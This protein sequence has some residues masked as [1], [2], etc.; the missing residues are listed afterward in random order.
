MKDVKIEIKNRKI[1]SNKAIIVE[2]GAGANLKSWYGKVLNTSTAAYSYVLLGAFILSFGVYVSSIVG[3][4]VFAITERNY[5]FKTQQVLATTNDLY[6]Q[7]YD[8]NRLAVSG[9]DLPANHIQHV[10]AYEQIGFAFSR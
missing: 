2:F 4:S 6:L 10:Y 7:S 8:A 9:L 1:A 3:I 5:D